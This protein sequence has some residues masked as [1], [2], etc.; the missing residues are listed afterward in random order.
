M[1]THGGSQIPFDR[2]QAFQFKV[3]KLDVH[4]IVTACLLNKPT[5]NRACSCSGRCCQV[6]DLLWNWALLLVYHI[7][8]GHSWWTKGKLAIS[9]ARNNLEVPR[10]GPPY[11]FHLNNIW[12]SQ[13]FIGCLAITA[14][15][16]FQILQQTFAPFSFQNLQLVLTLM[17]FSRPQI[18]TM[19]SPAGAVTSGEVADHEKS[20][21]WPECHAAAVPAPWICTKKESESDAEMI[22]AANFTF[23]SC[24]ALT[25]NT[26]PHVP[27]PPPHFTSFIYLKFHGN[28]VHCCMLS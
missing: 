5:S 8:I 23:V 18:C 15:L 14:T 2:V 25:H 17:S 10:Q 24:Q 21:Y 6:H 12:S 16:G 27:R 4:V 22:S 9:F 26:K 20:A 28:Q 13:T 19:L 11:E 1:N 7:S 3:A